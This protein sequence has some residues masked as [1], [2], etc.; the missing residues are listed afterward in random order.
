[1]SYP[2]LILLT[3]ISYFPLCYCN[4][5][6][7]STSF[8]SQK[9]SEK[10]LNRTSK[11]VS[12][13]SNHISGKT[14]KT[15]TKLC[16]F[17]TKIQRLLQKTSPETA[18]RLFA[19]G[20]PT[21]KTLLQKLKQ[22]EQLKHEYLSQFDD[23]RD[24]LAIN[25]KYIQQ[26]KASIDEKISKA[27]EVN[28]KL[29]KLDSVVSN[30]ESVEAFIRER[31]RVLIKQSLQFIGKNKYLKKINKEAYYYA[32]TLRTYKEIFSDEKKIE[33]TAKQLLRNMPEFQRFA[34][35]NSQ[36]SGLFASPASFP[37]IGSGGNMPVIN[38]LPSREVMQQF[39][40]T[41]VPTMTNANMSEVLQGKVSDFKAEIEKIKAYASGGNMNN[42]G[43]PDFK[44]NSQ[45]TKPFSKRLEYST[46][47]QFGESNQKL[48]S[49]INIALRVG[50]KFTDKNSAGFGISYV[51]GM[52]HG[53]DSIK[54]SHQGLGFRTYLKSK[55]NKGFAI[56]GGA[57]WNY[58]FAASKPNT[59]TINN[60]W[61]TSALLGLSKSMAAGKKAKSNVQIYYDFLHNKNNPL[62]KPFIFRYGYNFG[63]K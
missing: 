35:Q 23:Y 16:R 3:L 31:K 40:Q 36:L 17:E 2:K 34:A 24:K 10:Y 61:Q 14:I 44:T 45:K 47:I 59:Q 63:M 28:K 29:H 20:Q 27:S 37:V 30:T 55:L 1:M 9:I 19:P 58:S 43:L 38:G 46:D 48:P 18:N 41:S 57:E 15:L 6:A 8:L 33:E 53:W 51:L 54:L 25:V 60:M 26:Q 62:S 32:E 12:Y 42:D 4:A 22:G 39:F 21:F 11:K 56:Q 50:Y 13:Y 49:T 5:Q 52:G 7:D